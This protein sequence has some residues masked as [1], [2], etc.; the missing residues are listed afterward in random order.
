MTAN[1]EIM[2]VNAT[3][4]DEVR[5]ALVEGNNL[6]DLDIEYPRDIKKKANIYAATVTRLEASLEAAFVDYGSKR[7]GFLPLKEIS[8]D[9]FRTD[10]D[11]IDGKPNIRELLKE[12][13]QLLVQVDKDERGTKGA[14]LTTFITLAGCYLV[15]MPNNP[16]AGGISRR[17]EG[18]DRDELRD[19]LSGLNL[20]EGM[21]IIIRTAGVGK[22][23][24]DLQWDLD[25]L[26][27]QWEAIKN[28]YQKSQPPCLLHQE[29]DV[30]IRSIRDNLRKSVS[31]IIIDDHVAYSKA[32]NYLEQV[33]PEF[34]PYLK[35]YQDT[36]PLFNRYQIESQ[37]ELAF[38][39]LVVLPSG[40]SIVIDRTEALV[41]IDI[42]SSKATKG[43]D[44]ETTAFNTNC[45]AADEIARQ[46]RLRDLGGLIV[47]DFIDMNES[48]HQRE[49]ENRLREALRTDRARVQIGRISRFGLLEMS[50]QRL[51][52]SLGES[53]ATV[54]PRCE[55]RGSERSIASLALAIIRLIEEEA[56][57]A[58][59]A[60]VQVQVPVSLATFMLN[61]KR[62]TIQAIEQRHNVK[63]MILPNPYLDVPHYRISRLKAEE[64]E[65]ISEKPSFAMIQE[66]KLELAVSDTTEAAVPALTSIPVHQ[67]KP[68]AEEQTG[69]IKRLW[70]SLFGASSSS[71][72]KSARPQRSERPASESGDR[73]RPPHHRHRN[74]SSR[75]GKPRQGGGGNQRRRGGGGNPN[76]RGGNRSGGGDD[77]EG[78]GGGGGSSANASSNTSA[79]VND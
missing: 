2:L 59:T 49:V 8:P 7:Q 10:P 50:R 73:R 45:E 38:Q 72:D 15:L 63:V 1:Q 16:N 36:T 9:Y 56:L 54:C 21:G 77:Q 76:N 12:G 37:I 74:K 51:R 39:R 46:L 79:A 3:Q 19:I 22:S 71:S 42:N 11:K 35:L 69:F 26:L 33:K 75:G 24:E 64:L 5:V 28:V 55:G 65:E 53:T 58:Q 27:R 62:R 44:I 40:G 20:P 67:A 48:R 4:S 68:A 41:A 30:I 31:E 60:A 61:E 78:G 17:I 57:Q 34:L 70:D 23:T 29:G 13:Q 47:I 18:D 6:K 66:P 52:L 25:V 14:A 43:A 32:R